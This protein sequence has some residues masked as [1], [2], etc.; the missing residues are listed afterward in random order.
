MGSYRL[1]S[2]NFVFQ[3]HRSIFIENKSKA[4][5]LAELV[6]NEIKLAITYGNVQSQDETQFYLDQLT[7]IMEVCQ[8]KSK[9]VN[10]DFISELLELDK[11]EC[12]NR[13][14]TVVTVNEKCDSQRSR[15]PT[16]KQCVSKNTKQKCCP[17][18]I[19]KNNKR[20]H[21]SRP[22]KKINREK[23]NR[24]FT[25]VLLESDKDECRNGTRKVVTVVHKSDLQKPTNQQPNKTVSKNAKKQTCR[26]KQISKNN[27]RVHESKPK[28]KLI[29]IN[30]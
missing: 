6:C 2:V 11:E 30:K 20:V 21:V 19:S 16:T 12:Q 26:P 4:F 22:K 23:I 9:K 8:L 27:K 3:N 15:K 17:K 25:S 24:N 5:N 10:P 13:Y 18:Q 28:T 29:V 1:S 7:K 14:Q